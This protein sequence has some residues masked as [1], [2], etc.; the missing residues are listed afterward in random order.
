MTHNL[1]TLTR[2]PASELLALY[3]ELEAPDTAEMQGEYAATLLAQLHPLIALLGR[4]SIYNPL[5]PGYWLAKG[6]APT[7]SPNR[8]RGYNLFRYRNRMVTR[9][10]M[11]TLVHP[12]RFDG[13]PAYQLVYPAY[14]SIVGRLHMIDEL[15]RVD[16]G[17][18]LG[19]GTCGFT[20][21]QRRLRLPFALQGPIGKYRGIAG[22]PRAHADAGSI[23][24]AS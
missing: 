14:Q 4:W 7:D 21:R 2:L 5:Y 10:P 16:E 24:D 12:S 20:R 9:W 19:F 18:Y 1:S 8:G 13:K 23:I 17:L 6:F 11:Q 3:A 15:R 22:V